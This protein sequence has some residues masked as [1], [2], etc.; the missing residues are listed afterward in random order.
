MVKGRP[1]KSKSKEGG[2]TVV[3]DRYGDDCAYI[4]RS[5]SVE[6]GF[7]SWDA[8]QKDS[9]YAGFLKRYTRENLKRNFDKTVKRYNEWK[10][11]GGGG[12]KNKMICLFYLLHSLTMIL[13][14]S[15]V[16]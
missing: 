10:E 8:F 6:D 15:Q 2:T 3:W 5:L 1:T 7:K 4:I 16:I 9:A 14:P 12:F 13:L 11:N